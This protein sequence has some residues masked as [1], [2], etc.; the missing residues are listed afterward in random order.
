[1]V[2]SEVSIIH[3]SENSMSY[4]ALYRKFRPDNFDDVKGQDHIVTTLRN[5][6]LHDRVGHAYLFC[7]TRGTGKTTMAKLMAKAVNCEHPVNGNPCGECES[8]QSIA[9]GNSLNVIE[10]DAA[11]NNGVDN[12]RQINSAVQ[13]SPSQGK[14]LVYIIDEVHMMT[15][16][17]FNALLKTIEEPPEYVIFILATTE[18]YKVPVTI[19]SRCQ[20]YDFRRITVDTIAGRINHILEEEG[21]KATPEAVRYIARAA[22]GSMRDGLS[23]LDECVSASIGKTLDL[24]S[25][26]KIV[27]AV[28][29]D[30]YVK[31]MEAI[32][33]DKADQVLDIINDAV[34]QGKDLTVFT[35]NFIWFLRNMLFIKVS[36]QVAGELDITSE[37]VEIIKKLGESFTVDT[38]SRYIDLLQE[39]SVNIRYST[40]KRVSLEMTI[41]R[42]MRPES[43]TDL[44]SVL[45]R[46]DLL[47]AGR[48]SAP[49][50]TDGESSGAGNYEGGPGFSKE[51][52]VEI[53]HR[54]IEK[55]IN[56]RM[57][58]MPAVQT[59]RS[60]KPKKRLTLEEE[61]RL[62]EEEIRNSYPEATAEELIKLGKNWKNEIRP[63][64]P[65][66]HNE[67]L[68]GSVVVA[69][70]SIDGEFPKLKILLKRVEGVDIILDYYKT[71]RGA[72]NMNDILGDMIKRKVQTEY[73][74]Q[75]GEVLNVTD[76]MRVLN[77]LNFDNIEIKD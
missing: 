59:Q 8:C 18:D 4:V 20:R 53:I 48:A 10:I 70:E 52:T 39:L 6:L 57:A 50:V 21:L 43:D 54:E 1:M 3:W 2:F 75:G 17:A 72:E 31:L 49:A 69:G 63:N 23:I 36:P 16:S 56:I 47:E 51:E 60:E 38:L 29:I 65:G 71:G 26:L 7:G 55:A 76:E 74:I 61:A 11:S 33:D 44:S 14:Y 12:V 25:V 35:D 45:S 19:R 73:E 66:P 9:S 40:I 64:L 68:Q 46:L 24:D 22:D 67:Y 58:G 13:Y 28:D 77:K 32:R 42:M 27:G 37:N 15:S 34:W 62:V 30:I 41:I 5:Q